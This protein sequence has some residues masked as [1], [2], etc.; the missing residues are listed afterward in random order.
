MR[1]LLMFYADED[2]WLTLP[3][4]ERTAATGRIGQWFGEHARAGKIVDGK[5]LAGGK[6]A[7]TT[8]RLGRIQRSGDAPIVTDGPFVEAKEAVGSY[9]VVEVTD[10]DEA[11]A[12]A[13]SWPAGGLVEVRPVEE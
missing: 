12:I 11:I 7:T 4:P 2:A 10:R 5:R 3:E 6:R 9:A 1:Y 8:V 13:K